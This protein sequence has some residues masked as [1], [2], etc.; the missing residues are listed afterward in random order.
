MRNLADSVFGRITVS[1]SLVDEYYERSQRKSQDDK[2]LKQN[3]PAIVH[4]MEELGKQKSDFGDIRI[5][6]STPDESKFDTEKILVFLANDVPRDVFDRCTSVVVNEEAL[7]E[8]IHEG[9]IDLD[10]LKAIAWVEKAGT[11]RIM[12]KKL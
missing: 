3:K 1:Q 9:T 12:V 8:C 7:M 11:P 2:W 5:T 6:V 4:A 10:A